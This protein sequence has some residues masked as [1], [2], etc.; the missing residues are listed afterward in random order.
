RPG[1]AP[2]RPPRR[3]LPDPLPAYLRR[4]EPPEADLQ[5]PR[6]RRSRGARRLDPPVRQ[7]EPLRGASRRVPGERPEGRRLQPVR[8]DAGPL[9]GLLEE[10]G[11]RLRAVERRDRGPRGG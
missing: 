10:P 6:P 8:P 2:P 11:D 9:R 1:R 3:R 4:L 7:V 5:P